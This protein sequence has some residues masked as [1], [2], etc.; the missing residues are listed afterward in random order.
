MSTPLAGPAQALRSVR[1]AGSS[2][3]RAVRRRTAGPWHAVVEELGPDRLRGWVEVPLGAA[4]LRVGVFVNGVEVVATWTCDRISRTVTAEVRGFSL[5]LRDL[6]S[7]TRRSDRVS[8]RIDGVRLPIAGHGLWLTP[9]QDGAEGLPRL[10][11]ELASGRVFG[12]TG[13]LQQSR[14]LSTGWQRRVL[15]LYAEVRAVLA[16]E[17]GYDA[18]L[19]YGT[20]L[21]AVREGGFVAHDQGFDAA[22]V[23]KHTDPGKAARELQEIAFLLV[24]HGFEVEGRRAA[25]RVSDAEDPRARIDLFHLFF[26]EGGTLRYPFGAAGTNPVTR[27]DW[28][29]VRET[30]LAGARVVVPV[31]AEQLVEALYGSCWRLP[32][33]G[34]DWAVNRTE[35]AA[36]AQLPPAYRE[37][38][39]WASFYARNDFSSG[40][41]FQEHVQARGG[42]PDTVIDLGCGQGRDS[43]AFATAGRT[44]MGIDRSH[45]GIRHAAAKAEQVGLAG[46][47]S[48]AA[49]D[50]SDGAALSAVLEQVRERARGGPVLFYARFFLHSIPED[51]QE[52][53]LTIVASSARPGDAFAA[54]FRTDRDEAAAKVYTKHYRRF[55][56]GPAFGQRLAA[57]HGWKVVEEQEGTGLSPYRGEDPELY[58]VLARRP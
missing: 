1:Q 24:E 50:V 47:L 10:R 44:V 43:F 58:R 53:L 12:P 30:D 56:N 36:E 40:S 55:Q 9:A 21:G 7:Y 42:L 49:C 45:V 19:A 25:L 22:Y 2:V 16:A 34:F 4:P 27:A 33:P 5:P 39:Y 35:A 41:T 32:V 14:A 17:L 37:E 6:W 52:A 23:S 15:G 3:R 18:F 29:G 28:Q 31:R 13:R 57:V 11:K 26:D 20:L 51:V 38:V 8:V 54:E 48:F 46:R